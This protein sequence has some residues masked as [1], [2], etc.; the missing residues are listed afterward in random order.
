MKVNSD[1]HPTRRWRGAALAAMAIAAVAMAACAGDD[2]RPDASP[3]VAARATAT[4]VPSANAGGTGIETVD[5]VLE[6]I[7][8]RDVAALTELIVARDTPCSSDAGLGGP[9]SCGSTREPLPEGTLVRVF[10]WS[11]C[12]REWQTDIDAWAARF[13]E[14][15]GELYA[16][17]HI[18]TFTPQEELPGGG[19]AIIYTEANPAFDTAH[20]LIVTDTGIVAADTTC[21]G[22]A[23]TFL[24]DQPPFHAPEVIVRG[25]AFDE[26]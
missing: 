4:P 24:L 11:T 18:D 23:S 17:A 15:L 14:R 10:P 19:Y 5:R 8:T 1:R 9:P 21:G 6:A 13:V 2:D 12:E 3:T 20:A 16:V 7:A 26:E 22:P 25:P